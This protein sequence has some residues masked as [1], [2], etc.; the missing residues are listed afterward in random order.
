MLVNRRYNELGEY[1]DAN[2]NR[3]LMIIR[4]IITQPTTSY[5]VCINL[6]ELNLN[7]SAHYTRGKGYYEDYKV[8]AKLNEYSI[9]PVVTDRA[10]LPV[11]NG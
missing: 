2:G 7:I 10:D 11:R 8:R 9:A 6:T 1:V 3:Q 5:M 4:L